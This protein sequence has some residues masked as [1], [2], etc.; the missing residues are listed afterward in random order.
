MWDITLFGGG[1]VVVVGGDV[2]STNLLTEVSK[3]QEPLRSGVSKLF[4]LFRGD[5]II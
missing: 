1:V 5:P 3:Q 2:V 4:C